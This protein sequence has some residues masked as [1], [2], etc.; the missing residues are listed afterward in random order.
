MIV[1][2]VP[3]D[4]VE[5][6]LDRLRPIFERHSSFMYVADVAVSRQEYFWKKG[7]KP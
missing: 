7:G 2:V 4:K 1:T 3:E 6:I 5:P